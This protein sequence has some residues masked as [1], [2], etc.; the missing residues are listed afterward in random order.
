[1]IKAILAT[2]KDIMGNLNYTWLF[3]LSS[4]SLSYPM[5]PML[6]DDMGVGPCSISNDIVRS[7]R[8]DQTDDAD[9]TNPEN[10]R[11]SVLPPYLL[12]TLPV[13]VLH[14]TYE[15]LNDEIDPHTTFRDMAH[16]AKASSFFLVSV[17][18]TIGYSFTSRLIIFIQQTDLVTHELLKTSLK[19]FEEN[20]VL[21][22]K[23]ILHH[24]FIDP[25]KKQLVL[26]AIAQAEDEDRK[27]STF[28]TSFS[29]SAYQTKFMGI[30]QISTEFPHGD[31][32][33][34]K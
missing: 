23:S 3:I 28:R 7:Y 9:D 16:L 20:P 27:R 15:Q 12:S 2:G 25:F 19:E 24:V 14:L 10:D 31:L 17:Q 21:N 6:I 29:A 5:D 18:D 11:L 34:L 30:K 26:R 8:V 33:T 1:M 22:Q 13:D 32:S 4:I